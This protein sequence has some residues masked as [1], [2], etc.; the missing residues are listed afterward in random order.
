MMK[1]ETINII[2]RILSAMILINVGV[3]CTICTIYAGI[4]GF[5]ASIIIGIAIVA[6]NIMMDILTIK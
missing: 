3:L 2:E 5:V 1:K 6:I 4:K